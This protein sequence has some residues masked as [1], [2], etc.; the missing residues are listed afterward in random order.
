MDNQVETAAIAAGGQDYLTIVS[1][2]LRQAY[3]AT[4]LC[5]TPAKPYLFLKEISSDGNIQTVDVI[6][7]AHPAYIWTNPTMLKYLLD[8]L[9]ENQEAGDYPNMYSMHDLGSSYP[10]A[11]G[12]PAGNDEQMPL[13]ECGNMLIMTLN[14]AQKA[15]DTAYLKTHYTILKQ[16]TQYLVAEA[17]YPANQISTDDFAGSLA[18]QTNLALKGMIG[19]QAMS[20][21]ANLTGNTADAQN[22]STIAHSYISQWQTLG[23]NMADSPPHATLAYNDP[24]SHG[25]LYNLYAD[26]ALNLDLVPQSVYDIQSTFY[27]TVAA[28]YGVPLD[29]RHTYT[30]GDWEMFVAAIA[31]SSTQTLLI[32]D[33][34]KWIGETTTNLPL[35]DLYDT[36]T[37]DYPGITFAN[38]PVMGGSFAL[39]TLTGR[40]ESLENSG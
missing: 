35:T 8:P 22:Y 4:Q 36:V 15:D 31:D 33:L 1:L 5:G 25:L 30:K 2:A 28:T 13:E 24:T 3:G 39:L 6:F 23:F 37:G 21:I 9:F 18:N 14:Y 29:T 16:W 17:L 10:N 32:G 40:E 7:P 27:P 26:K 34:A 11:T 38:R 12:H 20:V 19:I